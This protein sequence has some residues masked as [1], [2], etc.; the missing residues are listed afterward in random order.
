MIRERILTSG[1][2]TAARC[3]GAAEPQPRVQPVP[4][5][6][7]DIPHRAVTGPAVTGGPDSLQ[8]RFADPDS[9]L[10]RP[11]RHGHDSR[12]PPIS[13]G[14]EPARR[15]GTTEIDLAKQLSGRWRVR[16]RQSGGG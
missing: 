14:Q 10:A 3:A 6:A 5:R 15:P 2:L 13:R 9:A 4:R 11:V 12:P 1:V 16:Q 8:H 7:P